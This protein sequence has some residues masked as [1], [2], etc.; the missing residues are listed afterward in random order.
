MTTLILAA[1]MALVFAAL[2]VF[3]E[4]NPMSLAWFSRLTRRQLMRGKRRVIKLARD[5]AFLPTILR[6]WLRHVW[7][8]TKHSSIGLLAQALSLTLGGNRYVWHLKLQGHTPPS[9]AQTNYPNGIASRG[10]PVLGGGIPA[11]KGDV[12]HVDSGHTNADDGNAGKN[13]NHPIS[14]IDAAIGKCTASN[15]DIILV[16]EGH[17]EDL[18]SAGEIDADVAGISIIGLGQGPSRPRIDFNAT[19]AKFSIGA[20]G[21][22]LR[23]LTFRPSVA[24]VVVGIN[25][26]TTNTD[27]ILEGLEAVPGEAAD[28]TDEFVDFI[29]VNATCTRTSIDGLLYSHHA[30]ADG[31]QTAVSVVGASDRVRIGNFW[32]EGSGTAWVAGIQGITTLST[33]MLIENGVITCDAEPGIELLTGTTGTIRDVD[34]FSNLATIDA[35]TV[36]DGMAHMRVDYCE[37]GNEQGAR[38]KTLSIDD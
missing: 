3:D 26:E 15:G 22:R 17:V 13:P 34:I 18:G 30:S 2:A 12:Y 6:L 7:V 11:T 10:V 4:R 8:Q 24:L 35:A 28:G 36:A 16:S 38:V 29:V 37:V 14:T 9:G 1:F 19:D 31:A 27:T 20:S 21:V 23:N 32:I 5:F 25:I 33:R